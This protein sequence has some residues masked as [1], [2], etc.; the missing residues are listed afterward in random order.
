MLS[1]SHRQVSP[2]TR[3]TR[4]ARPDQWLP[5]S[6]RDNESCGLSCGCIIYNVYACNMH[7]CPKLVVTQTLRYLTRH[8]SIQSKQWPALF[9]LWQFI[10]PALFLPP[11]PKQPIKA[12]SRKNLNWF[13]WGLLHCMRVTEYFIIRM[14]TVVQEQGHEGHQGHEGLQG[15]EGHQGYHDDDGDGMRPFYL[16]LFYLPSLLPTDSR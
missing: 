14:G 2:G 11:C 7:V 5:F 4:Y 3:F 15:H 12:A 6:S 9:T 1:R 8:C 16:Q 13:C 10:I